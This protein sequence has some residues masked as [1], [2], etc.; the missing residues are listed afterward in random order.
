[1]SFKSFI[2]N[3]KEVLK[4]DIQTRQSMQRLPSK[5]FSEQNSKIFAAKLVFQALQIAM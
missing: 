2:S 4:H 3:F 1:M 5:E